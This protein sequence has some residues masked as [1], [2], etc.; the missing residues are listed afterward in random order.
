[1]ARLSAAL[2]ALVCCLGIEQHVSARKKQVI[3]HRVPPVLTS[4]SPSTG[5][6]GATVVIAGHDLGV[7]QDDGRVSFNGTPA[8]ATA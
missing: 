3:I 7:T 4:L 8:T 6:V 2:V 5:A 1:M